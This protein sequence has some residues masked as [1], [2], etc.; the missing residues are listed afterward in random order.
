MADVA[1]LSGFLVLAV[2]L[3]PAGQVG[4]SLA[5][6]QAEKPRDDAPSRRLL[7]GDD[8][9][10]VDELDQRITELSDA[11]RYAEAQVPARTI[12]ALRTRVQGATHWQTGNA[13][14]D[15]ETLQQIATL[16]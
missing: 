14:R 11:G 4:Q 16:P 6:G 8:A 2:S 12:L 15:L 5:S 1:F 7:T 9:K 13:K 3:L 10:Q